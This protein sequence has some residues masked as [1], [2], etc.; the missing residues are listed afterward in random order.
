MTGSLESLLRHPDLW[1]GRSGPAAPVGVVPTGRP[2]FDG[3]LPG[4]GWPQGALVEV[5]VG[6]AGIGEV[7]LLLPGLARLAREGRPS[8]WVDP[9][10]VPYAPALAEDGLDLTRLLV[11]RAA[12][13]ALWAAEQAL[14]SGL[15][16]AV[17]AWPGETAVDDR[18]LRRL[19]L[20]AEE[21]RALGV[22]FRS[23]R[24]A[25]APSPAR[26]RLLLEPA[27]Q[28]LAVRLLK[29]RGRGPSGR[30]VVPLG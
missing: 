17:L 24:H 4:G 30:F 12:A 16:G 1:R 28:G 6:R 5:L 20:A 10:Y 2:D 19:Q 22:L 21:G 26:L 3:A 13:D 29:C 14:R 27:G 15:C 23:E 25:G 7:S 11:V 9:P 18:A 8:V